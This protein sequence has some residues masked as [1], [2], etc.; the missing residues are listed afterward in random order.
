MKK[1]S[2]R[3]SVLFLIMTLLVSCSG[4]K[5]AG[6]AADGYRQADYASAQ[7]SPEVAANDAKT[8]QSQDRKL[9]KTGDISLSVDSIE[10]AQKKFT[11]IAE[12]FGGYV[13]S[14]NMNEDSGSRYLYMEIKVNA[15]NF[16]AAMDSLSK[17]GVV[18]RTGMNVSDVTKQFTDL[19]ARLETLKIKE[20][21]LQ[22]LLAKATEIDDILD[23]ENNLQITRE[24]IEATQGELNVIQNT[25]EYSL[26]TVS[27]S[28]KKGLNLTNPVSPG[29]RFLSALK[30][31]L[32]FWKSIILSLFEFI[33][34]S[35]PILIP[36]FIVT[37]FINK[38]LKKR[39]KAKITPKDRI[40]ESE[41][42]E[43]AGMEK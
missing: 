10:E 16:D 22:D 5:S 23:I 28:D 3:I 41:S 20:K 38:H 37:Y 17:T 29:E 11:E 8:I 33:L 18:R 1:N 7:K 40:A 34:F 19:S 36:L 2:L 14:S 13:F 24:G 21:T 15:K 6:T 31:G 9:V 43:S 4:S 26:I 30:S 35:L 32:L 39:R 25:T 42:K 27:A 12:K